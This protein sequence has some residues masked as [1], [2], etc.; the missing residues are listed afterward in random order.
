MKFMKKSLIN[1]YKLEAKIWILHSG[2][3]TPLT[4]FFP[5]KA[6]EAHNNSLLEL[7]K[8]ARNMG[9][10]IAVEN[11]L[12]GYELFNSP[13]NG[14]KILEDVKSENIGLCFDIGH[15]NLLGDIDSFLEVFSNE[16]I[17]I[18]IHDNDGKEDS[19]LPVGEG[20]IKWKNF[21]DWLEKA[22]YKG[23]IVFENYDVSDV[24]RGIDFLADSSVTTHP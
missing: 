4:Y 14:R 20:S 11:M 21:L 18:H 19:H 15:A 9:V 17:H 5:E 12:G 13:K 7:S 23:W 16:I 2:R 3:F 1:A 6:W 24:K 8:E 10:G 22:K